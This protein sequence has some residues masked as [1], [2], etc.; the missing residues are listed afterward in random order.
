MGPFFELTKLT[1]NQD[2]I[3]MMGECK[4]ENNTKESLIHGQEDQEFVVSPLFPP[5]REK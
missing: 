5:N 2:K 4:N 1:L 3:K